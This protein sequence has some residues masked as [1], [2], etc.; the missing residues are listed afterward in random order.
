MQAALKKDDSVANL[1][2]AFNIAASVGGSEASA[3]FD[4]VEDA[5]VQADEIN[6]KI[7]QF[8]GGLSVS[9]NIVT[10]A[11]ILSKVVG[12]TPPISKMQA[13][14][15]ANYFLNRKNV[16]QVKGAWHVLSALQTLAT[17]DFH[18]PVTVTVAS[19]PSVSSS[20]P[21]VRVQITDV[22]GNSLGKM[23]VQIDSAMRQSDG[24]VVM[25]K[26]LMKESS[27]TFYEVD[28]MAAKPGRGFYELTVTA[29]PAGKANAK[30][31]GNEAAVLLVKVLGSVSV[32][33]VE[34][35][36]GDADQSTATKT[37][38]V[39][40]NDKLKAPL[41]ADHHHKLVMK[42]AVTD[43]GEKVRVHQAFV[44]FALNDA[45]I[46]YVAEPDNAGNYKFDLDVSSKAK[47]FG[48]KSGKYS[49]HLII[50]DAVI[51]NPIDWYVGDINLDFPGK[52]FFQDSN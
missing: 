49:I 11:Y 21:L 5:V 30:L 6:G 19:T 9:S 44:R 4:R 38:K 34:I 20:S 45:E 40:A 10:G 23:N 36:V 50:G 8:E 31:V 47:E 13:V 1:G 35:G 17:N 37:T 16:N 15:F 12:K 3:V 14:K 48:S 18:T 27:D 32:D 24:A 42:F 39:A 7:L 2:L 28:L 26:S 33:S 41:T 43:Q 25:S 29:N 22:F 51:N 46:I 52:C